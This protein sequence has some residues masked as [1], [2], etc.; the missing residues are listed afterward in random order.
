MNGCDR[1]PPLLA[2]GR[3]LLF[4]VLL[5][6]FDAVSYVFYWWSMTVFFFSCFLLLQ[7]PQ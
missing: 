4:Q 5:F 1:A 6:V 2:K 3:Q 7:E